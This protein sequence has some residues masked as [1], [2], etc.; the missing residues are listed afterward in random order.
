[1]LFGCFEPVVNQINVFLCRFDTAGL[2][3]LKTVR[4]LSAHLHRPQSLAKIVNHVFRQAK[5]VFF[6]R[7]YPVQRLFI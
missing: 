7:T 3:L 1:M 5:Q 4:R 6:R 2:F